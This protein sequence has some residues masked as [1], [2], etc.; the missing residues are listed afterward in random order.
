MDKKSVTETAADAA[1]VVVG[2]AAMAVDAL[3]GADR[4]ETDASDQQSGKAREEQSRSE[5]PQPS[6]GESGGGGTASIAGAGSPDV[7]SAEARS[8]SGTIDIN[9]AK[10]DELVSLKH[11]GRGRAKRIIASRPFRSVEDLASQGIVPAEVLVT[12]RSRLA[13]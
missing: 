10:F 7:T 6:G 8:S 12:L 4:P 5:M 1:K 9:K 3:A 11:I 2:I 13:L